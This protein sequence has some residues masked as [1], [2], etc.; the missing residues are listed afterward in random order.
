VTINSIEEL[1]SVKDKFQGI[2]TGIE[3]GAGIMKA[4][5]KRIED[6]NLDF[7]LQ[8]SSSAGMAARP[9]KS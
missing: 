9:E 1:N 2:I 6:Y 5:N 8:S 7:G 3:P 4:T